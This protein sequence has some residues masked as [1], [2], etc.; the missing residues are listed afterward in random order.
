MRASEILSEEIITELFGSPAKYDFEKSRNGDLIV[1]YFEIND[2]KYQMVFDKYSNNS[3]WD[4]SYAYHSPSEDR[5]IAKPKGDMNT[6]NAVKVLS[7]VVKIFEDFIR[8]QKPNIVT[9]TGQQENKL[10]SLYTNMIKILKPKLASFD[11]SVQIFPGAAIDDFVVMNNK[12]D[13]D[14]GKLREELMIRDNETKIYELFKPLSVSWYKSNNID[15]EAR[16]EV[17][18]IKYFFNARQVTFGV[19]KNTWII[20]YGYNN[21]SGLDAFKPAGDQPNSK[22]KVLSIVVS[23]IVLLIKEVQPEKIYFTGEKEHN[24]NKLYSGMIRTLTPII[25]RLGYYGTHHNEEFYI[26]KK[27]SLNEHASGGGTSAGN[28]ATSVG[29][30]GSGFDPDADH[31]IYGKNPKNKKAKK[32][33]VVR[34]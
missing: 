14:A 26:C 18:D 29:G 9:F 3:Y 7:T 11:Y 34:R 32:P 5:F 25:D 23:Y 28:V 10:A 20:E 17:N 31:G 21:G 30:L 27:D 12:W 19:D 4:V 22:F 8:S 16:F 1:C 24:L 13:R 6:N 2:T 33:L 15:K